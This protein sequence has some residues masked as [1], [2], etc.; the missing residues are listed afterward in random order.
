MSNSFMQVQKLSDGTV[1][2]DVN[3]NGVSVKTDSGG[4]EVNVG[5]K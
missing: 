2:T 4:T 3:T 5:K 1:T